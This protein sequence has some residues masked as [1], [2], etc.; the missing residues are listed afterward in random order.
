LRLSRISF[1]RCNK[2]K[3]LLGYIPG[4]LHAKRKPVIPEFYNFEKLFWRLGKQSKES[5]YSSVSLYDISCNRS[6]IENKFISFEEDVLWNIDDNL[7]FE[8][9]PSE[10]IT[11]LIKR[12][13]PKNPAQKLIFHPDDEDKLNQRSVLLKLIHNPLTCNYAHCMFV[14]ELNGVHV[15]KQN[16]NETFDIKSLKR[17]RQTC[18]DE[19]HKAILRKEI[20]I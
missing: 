6:G 17:L 18:R 14:F 19:L 15:T 5:P 4:H 3:C 20:E 11:L 13:Y 12:I 10:I 9:H 16:Y 2:N 8:K 1:F 7:H